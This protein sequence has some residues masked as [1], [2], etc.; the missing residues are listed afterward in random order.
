MKVHVQRE[1]KEDEKVE[2][3]EE[4]SNPINEQKYGIQLKGDRKGKLVNDI[5]TSKENLTHEEQLLVDWA[6]EII[7]QEHNHGETSLRSIN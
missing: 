1:N 5:K 6:I 4:P 2:K 7:K 3:M